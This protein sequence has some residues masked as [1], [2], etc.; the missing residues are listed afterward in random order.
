MESSGKMRNPSMT[1]YAVVSSSDGA[2]S[3]E[4]VSVQY[5]LS[6]LR[7]AVRNSGMPDPDWWLTDW[8]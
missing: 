6:E 4:L 8:V 7:R 2:L 3:V 1:E 5:S